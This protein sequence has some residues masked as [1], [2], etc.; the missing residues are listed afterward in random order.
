MSVKH[1]IN[2]FQPQYAPNR[3]IYETFI[4]DE[5]ASKYGSIHGFLEKGIGL[6]TDKQAK[7][8]KNVS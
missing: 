6:S 1:F 7:L 5:M 4:F 2:G 3:A 8:K